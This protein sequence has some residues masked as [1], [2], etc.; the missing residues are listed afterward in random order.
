[1]RVASLIVCCLLGALAAGCAAWLGDIP[2]V[3][4]NSKYTAARQ[5]VQHTPASLFVEQP[6]VVD[7][8]DE[9]D[10]TPLIEKYSQALSSRIAEYTCSRNV[11]TRCSDKAIEGAYRLSSKVIVENFRQGHGGGV[12]IFLG[13]LL[14]PPLLGLAWSWPVCGGTCDYLVQWTL[15]SPSGEQLWQFEGMLGDGSASCHSPATVSGFLVRALD[16]ALPGMSQA[17]FAAE[18]LA[19]K[20]RA[21]KPVEAPAPVPRPEVRREVLAVFDIQD[22]NGK[23]AKKEL[24][25][26]T[27]FL[28]TAMATTNRFTLVPREQLRERLIDKKKASYRQC[29]DNA[30][31]IEL[32]KAVAA[33]KTLST[34][35]LEVGEE[36]AVVANL[37]DLRSET[38]SAAAM[39][40][41]GCDKGK[42]MG[43][44]KQVAEQIVTQMK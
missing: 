35:L 29:Y 38:T 7:K 16:K 14:L 34:Q 2:K 13:G 15:Y 17:A 32:G 19:T 43:A 30:C 39:V 11:F 20:A 5:P 22:V 31:Q 41:T 23:L 42:L 1:M 10:F 40:Q 25:Q 37:Y 28:A 18:E 36:C 26:L 44:M 6:E 3:Q 24:S 9:K 27:T 4:L 8:D 33:E 21:A 12:G